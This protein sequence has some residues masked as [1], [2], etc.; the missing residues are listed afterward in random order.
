MTTRPGRRDSGKAPTLGDYLEHYLSV[1]KNELAPATLDLHK[2]TGRYLAAYFGPGQRID[3]IQRADARKFKAA[4]AEGKLQSAGKKKTLGESTQHQHI[5]NARRIFGI[6]LEDDLINFNPFDRMAGRMPPAKGFHEVTT[7]EF[8]K[9][10]EAASPI[11]QVWIALCFYAGLRR[12][13]ALYLRWE[14]IDWA[15][16]RLTVIASADWRPKD[17]DSRVVPIVPE[18]RSILLERFEQAAEGAAYIIPRGSVDPRGCYWPFQRLCKRAGVKPW[19][20][21]FHTLRKTRLTRWARDFPQH[22]VSEWAGHANIETTAEY[23]LQISESEYDRA[24]GLP[25]KAGGKQ[26]A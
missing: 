5:R 14:N 26:E 13:E 11:W 6:A 9:L 3:M 21:P 18:L 1:R 2:Q 22:V 17:R 15:R 10:Y 8:Q 19:T 12:G 24:A 23:Y 7:D 25:K 16:S 4:L 20:Q